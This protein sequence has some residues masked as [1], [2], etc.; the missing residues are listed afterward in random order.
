MKNLYRNSILFH[1]IQ[2][3]HH[4]FLIIFRHKRGRQPEAERPPGRQR[5]LPREARIVPQY[6]VIGVLATAAADD[7][8]GQRFSLYRKLNSFYFFRTGFYGYGLRR[9]NKNSVAK[10][11]EIERNIFVGLL[12]G[13]ASILIDQFY[14][15]SVFDKGRENAL[16]IRKSILPHPVKALPSSGLF[17]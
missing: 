5:R 15:L 9:I 7:T 2:K 11:A 6:A 10:A 13:S 3:F 14:R 1:S 17:H 16:P 8:V 12:T 4:S